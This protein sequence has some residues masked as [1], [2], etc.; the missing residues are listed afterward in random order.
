MYFLGKN[1]VVRQED[2]AELMYKTRSEPN[3]LAFVL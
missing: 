3:F 1:E 2:L